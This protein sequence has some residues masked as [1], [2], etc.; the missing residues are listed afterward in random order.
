ML[1]NALMECDRA[2]QSAVSYTTPQKIYSP[3]MPATSYAYTPGFRNRLASRLTMDKDVSA[4]IEINNL[5]IYICLSF[6]LLLQEF[7]YI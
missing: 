2:A 4:N 7:F 5:R 1:T 3:T 6:S